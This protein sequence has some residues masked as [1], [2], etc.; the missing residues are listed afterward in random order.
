MTKAEY[1]QHLKEALQGYDRSFAEEILESYE[2]HFADG[3]K[4][5]RTE[6]EIC[7]ELGKIENFM[8]D[9]EDMMGDKDIHTHEVDHFTSIEE[10]KER[11]SG[12][13]KIELALVSMNVKVRPS[14]DNELHVYLENGREKSKYLQE[15]ISGDSYYAREIVD[16]NHKKG[17]ALKGL[18]FIFLMGISCEEDQT[19]VV[20]V[21][22]RLNSLKIKTMSGDLKLQEVW[23]KALTLETMSGDIEQNKIYAE[24]AI[25]KTASGDIQL[26]D[27]K[28][29]DAVLQTTSG[30][31]SW[32]EGNVEEAQIT[33]ISGDV[34][35]M[36]SKANRL[37][38][39]TTSGEVELRNSE[40]ADLNAATT[41]GDIEGTFFAEK[42]SVQSIS[43][44]IDMT[45]DRRGR[46]LI[47]KTKSVSG[48]CDVYGRIHYDGTPD[49]TRHIVGYFS[50]IS[51][52]IEIR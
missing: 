46:E 8:K 29:K 20:E 27:G 6:E 2:E 48:D 38:I 18:G 25:L 15:S 11:Y 19:L 31:I 50:T 36:G 9:I 44:D 28:G 40:I 37:K 42:L 17:S 39:K 7:D 23:S 5:G 33:T 34:D 1:M 52:D 24:E 12:I 45:L 21:P 41:S 35:F 10:A 30:D 16:K 47:A 32:R 22:S 49:P 4:S 43:G 3:I 13:N 51:G 26:R 14:E